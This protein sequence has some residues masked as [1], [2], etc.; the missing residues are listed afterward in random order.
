MKLG[1]QEI[2]K[3]EDA[4]L[5]DRKSL[6]YQAEFIAEKKREVFLQNEDSTSRKVNDF[7][8]QGKLERKGQRDEKKANK[9]ENDFAIKNYDTGLKR[10]YDSG[11]LTMDRVE[12]QRQSIIEK[13]RGQ[14]WLPKTSQ[15]S[16][17]SESSY[18]GSAVVSFTNHNVKLD[19]YLPSLT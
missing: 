6:L 11:D 1:E 8:L 4:P 14:M 7:E 12:E 18:N 3:F 10:F 19:V 5:K 2:S 17:L 9:R 13:Q 15:E 16:K